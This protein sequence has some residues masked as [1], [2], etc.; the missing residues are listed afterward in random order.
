MQA[1]GYIHPT[2]FLAVDD[3]TIKSR[4]SAWSAEAPGTLLSFD[5][6]KH[7]IRHGE[8]GFRQTDDPIAAI[9]DEAASIAAAEDSLRL[10]D[11]GRVAHIDFRPRLELHGEEAVL[12]LQ[13]QVDLE[14]GA[15]ASAR[16]GLC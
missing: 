13:D 10:F 6:Q 15:P 2:N 4:E 16:P 8:D 11:R 14:P 9:D 7:P 12:L 5:A 1:Y 3:Y